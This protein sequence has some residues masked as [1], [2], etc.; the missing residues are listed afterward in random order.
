MSDPTDE[1][2]ETRM[3]QRAAERR[4]ERPAETFGWDAYTASLRIAVKLFADLAVHRED[5]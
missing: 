4:H 1:G 5:T 3:A 2:W